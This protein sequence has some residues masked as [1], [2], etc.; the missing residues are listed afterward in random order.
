M[1]ATIKP[2]PWYLR[3]L[4]PQR[5]KRGRSALILFG[6]FLGALTSKAA[7]PIVSCPSSVSGQVGAAFSYQISASNSPT[8]FGSI[9]LPPGLAVSSSTGLISGAPTSAGA[10]EVILAASN[11]SGTGSAGLTLIVGLQQPVITS[12][13]TA[14][15]E[16]GVY[17]T[18]Q[19]VA[20][21]DPTGF[22]ASGLPGGLSID[23][24]YGT[25]SGAP[26]GSG[27]SSIIINATNATGTGALTL[28]LV[29]TPAIPMINNGPSAAG[30]TGV[31]FGYPISATNS[32]TGYGAA[33]LPA[34]LTVNAST[35]MISGTVTTPGTTNVTLS[36]TNSLGTGTANL[37]LTFTAA[38]ENSL[39]YYTDFEVGKGFKPG[40]LPTANGWSVTQGSVLVTSL[41]AYSGSQSIALEAGSSAAIASMSVAPTTGETIEFFDFYA[42]PSAESSPTSSTVFTVEGAK[43]CYVKSGSSGILQT[44]NGNGSGGGAW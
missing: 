2:L 31:G 6:V 38:Q 28:S 1:T 18:Y 44:F 39:P 33:G 11:S 14:T 40:P 35:G 22:S 30:R 10:W 9:N 7:I 12:P 4:R 17:F 23:P 25:I 19:V 24:N 27:T 37:T 34:G 26:A 15:A 8:S 20:S 43:F 32:P 21:G 42:T 3:N 16:V 36:A 13:A 41:T 5:L 29:V